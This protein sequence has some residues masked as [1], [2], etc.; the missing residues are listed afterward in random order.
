M[1][2][3]LNASVVLGLSLGS[4]KMS[5]NKILNT[6]QNN[7]IRTAAIFWTIRWVYSEDPSHTQSPSPNPLFSDGDMVLLEPSLQAVLFL[8]QILR[9]VCFAVSRRE[10]MHQLLSYAMV[11]FIH[12]FNSLHSMSHNSGHRHASVF[13]EVH[14]DNTLEEK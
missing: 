6:G 11:P 10:Q 4:C 8:F 2:F 12:N 14:E 7:L 13:K 5:L 3:Y 9:A 1:E